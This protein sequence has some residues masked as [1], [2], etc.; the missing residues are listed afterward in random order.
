MFF[1]IANVHIRLNIDNSVAVSY[2]NN[3]GGQRRIF[4]YGVLIITLIK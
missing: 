1:H 3:I 4:G 2:F